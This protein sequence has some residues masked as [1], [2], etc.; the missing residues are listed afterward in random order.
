M[1]LEVVWTQ[2][3]ESGYDRIITYLE[4]QFTDKEVRKF[5]R[6]SHDFFELLSKYPKML[7]KTGKQ[8]DVYRGPINKHTILTYRIKPRKK[9]IELINKIYKAETAKAVHTQNPFQTHPSFDLRPSA[10]R[11]Q[12][13]FS[14]NRE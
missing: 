9:Q 3:A 10:Q 4:N 12:A 6:Q 2:R 11:K 13:F 1:A 8:K 14:V 7:E 5:V